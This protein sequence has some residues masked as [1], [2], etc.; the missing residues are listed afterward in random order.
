MAACIF[1][2]NPVLIGMSI[3]GEL[4]TLEFRK[5]IGSEKRTYK[6]VPTDK[7]Y[8]LFYKKTAKEVMSFYTKNIRKKFT[9]V[10]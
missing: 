2:Y 5:K 3:D 1:P 9:R 7:S 8:G 6:E 4:M 10:A